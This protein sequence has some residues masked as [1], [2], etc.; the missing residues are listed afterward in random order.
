MKIYVGFGRLIPTRACESDRNVKQS[1]KVLIFLKNQ[2][3]KMSVAR[4]NVQARVTRVR[5]GAG[6]TSSSW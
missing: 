4:H 1:N 5:F 3:E 6:N 2:L